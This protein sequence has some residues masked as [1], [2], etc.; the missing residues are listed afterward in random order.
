MTKMR[1]NLTSKKPSL[2]KLNLRKKLRNHIFHQL[3]RDSKTIREITLLLPSTSQISEMASKTKKKLDR[4]NQTLTVTRAMEMKTNQH[5]SSQ[6]QL[7][8]LN[9]QNK[10]SN[11]F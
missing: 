5:N 10:V 9:N 1:T 3:K 4:S 2:S 8:R 7:V 11:P 6:M